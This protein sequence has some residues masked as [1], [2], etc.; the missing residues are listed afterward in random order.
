LTESIPEGISSAEISNKPS[1]LIGTHDIMVDISF[2]TF[3]LSSHPSKLFPCPIWIL[4]LEI[5]SQKSLPQT[6]SKQGITDQL[7][8]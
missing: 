4:F 6:T 8:A 3:T 7:I 1:F 2:S 5:K